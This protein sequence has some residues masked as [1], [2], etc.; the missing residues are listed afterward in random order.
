MIL[1]F[2]HRCLNQFNAMFFDVK[3]I[4]NLRSFT[5]FSRGCAFKSVDY[6]GVNRDRL[7]LTIGGN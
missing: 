5:R 6:Q 2:L 1:F 3:S 7:S 4:V